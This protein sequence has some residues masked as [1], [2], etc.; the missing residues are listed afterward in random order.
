M[1]N[2]WA[3]ETTG[4]EMFTSSSNCPVIQIC[5]DFHVPPANEGYYPNRIYILSEALFT[6]ILP[7]ITLPIKECPVCVCQKLYNRFRLTRAGISAVAGPREHDNETWYVEI[8]QLNALNYILLYFSFTM[9]LTCFGK[10]MPSSGSDYVP[11][12]ATSASIW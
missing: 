1:L 10:T 7:W 6:V 4:P 12:S 2:Y 8:N 11:F 5:R 3:H 9:A